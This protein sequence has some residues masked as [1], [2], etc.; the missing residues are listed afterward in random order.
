VAGCKNFLGWYASKDNA[1]HF[2]FPVWSIFSAQAVKSRV[3]TNEWCKISA[4]LPK[5]IK[6]VQFRAKVNVTNLNFWEKCLNPKTK[7]TIKI[8]HKHKIS[9]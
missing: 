1:A 6:I 3:I 5:T 8:Q 4:N 9:Q 2:V 7:F